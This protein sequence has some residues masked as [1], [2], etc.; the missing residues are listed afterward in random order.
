MRKIVIIF[1]I[2]LLCNLFANATD[3][4]PEKI[5]AVAEH[6]INKET[7]NTTQEISL[8]SVDDYIL[9]DENLKI[10]KGEKLVFTL[11]SYSAPTRGKRNGTYKVTLKSPLPKSGNYFLSGTMNVATSKDLMNTAKNLGIKV[12]G[13]ALKIPGFSQAVA[14]A[15]GIINPDEEKGRFR[16]VSRNVYETTPLKYAEKGEDFMIEP[17]GIVVIKLRNKI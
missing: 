17:D 7:I 4:V 10:K 3:V 9:F 11:D 15:K 6:E 5:L 8:Y 2:L 1:G 14:A 12:V 16:S 13:K